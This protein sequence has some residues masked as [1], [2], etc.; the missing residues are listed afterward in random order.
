MVFR[1]TLFGIASI[2][3][4][5]LSLFCAKRFELSG[6]K[7][8]FLAVIPFYLSWQFIS[9]FLEFIFLAT[10]WHYPG[11]FQYPYLSKSLSEFWGRR[12]ATWV[13]DWL[14]E[15]VMPRYRKKPVLGLF[16]AFLCSGIWHELLLNLPLYLFFD[17]NIFGSQTLYFLIQALGIL[18]E[19]RLKQ[20]S[21][22]RFAFCWAVILIPAPL[23]VNDAVLRV[24][25]LFLE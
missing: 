4:L 20:G 12:W 6:I 11:H 10:G 24:C 1:G 7:L 13:S 15:M 2:L 8:N 23:V 18:G 14:S 16:L 17:V 22:Y 5:G 19:R 21:F 25:G 9:I 3:A